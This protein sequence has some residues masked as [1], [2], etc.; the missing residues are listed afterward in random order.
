VILSVAAKIVPQ[1][2]LPI[3][4]KGVNL[5]VLGKAELSSLILI[6]PYHLFIKK[7]PF[8]QMQRDGMARGT[9]LL[10]C[11]MQTALW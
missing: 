5:F 4:D 1:V 2:P 11:M 9:T 8:A 10:A 3:T 7:T 6:P